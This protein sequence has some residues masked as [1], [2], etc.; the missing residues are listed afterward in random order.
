MWEDKK[1]KTLSKFENQLWE[2]Y[3]RKTSS[4]FGKLISGRST[5]IDW[6]VHHHHESNI[7]RYTYKRAYEQE[8]NQH[9]QQ[10]QYEC[11]DGI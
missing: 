8:I 11:N 3:K 7:I 5:K 6:I 4:K 1:R 2:G 9:I 10:I